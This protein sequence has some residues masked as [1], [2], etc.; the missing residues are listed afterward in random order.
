MIFDFISK[1][2]KIIENQEQLKEV[3]KRLL[4]IRYAISL[5]Y[6]LACVLLLLVLYIKKQKK[7]A[8]L[9]SVLLCV[10]PI[11][12][13]TTL[14]TMGFFNISMI[15]IIY[16]LL[17]LPRDF[18]TSTLKNKVFF[19]MGFTFC[20]LIQ[21]YSSGIVSIFS[22]F[23]FSATLLC[24]LLIIQLLDNLKTQP[25][26][27]H[28][29]LIIYPII[30]TFCITISIFVLR[31]IEMQEASVLWG[32]DISHASSML[33]SFTYKKYPINHFLS[34]LYHNLS[35][36]KVILTQNL[37]MIFTFMKINI[38]FSI[39]HIIGLWLITVCLLWKKFGANIF[40]ENWKIF[41]NFLLALV[42]WHSYL[43]LCILLSP[44]LM[45]HYVSVTP[46]LGF[47]Y[48]S[49]WVLILGYTLDIW[50]KQAKII[51]NKKTSSL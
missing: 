43:L 46:I 5:F 23:G 20:V 40:I 34:I 25:V 39:L 35:I 32:G 26:K 31:K 38:S 7:Q 29:Y 41:R 3:S 10:S 51:E 9:L 1:N 27:K 17:F 21:Q 36:N 18:Y 30:L 37:G 42:L 4:Y 16:I 19:I 22:S 11:F 49:I 13:Y 50:F 8:Y 15:Q 44:W 47:Y 45:K 48:A 6:A 33:K 24:F 28:I 2:N 12:L 14:T